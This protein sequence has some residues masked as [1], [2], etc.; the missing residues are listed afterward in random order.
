MVLFVLSFKR[1][2]Q[3]SE[4]EHAANAAEIAHI[5]TLDDLFNRQQTMTEDLA[6]EMGIDANQVID[7]FRPHQ[8]SLTQ[9]HYSTCD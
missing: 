5:V 4:V 1:M 2:M 8:S 3:R 7:A 9:I 6:S